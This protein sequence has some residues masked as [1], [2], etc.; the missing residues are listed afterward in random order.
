MTSKKNFLIGWCLTR[1]TDSTEQWKDQKMT[2]VFKR[3]TAAKQ[4]SLKVANLGV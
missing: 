1:F 3:A 4:T 2:A